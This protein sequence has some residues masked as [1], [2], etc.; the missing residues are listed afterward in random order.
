MPNIE[1]I[2]TNGEIQRRIIWVSVTPN[3]LYCDIISETNTDRHY[4]IHSDGSFWY[5]FAGMTIKDNQYEPLDKLKGRLQLVTFDFVPD[6]TRIYTPDYKMVKL[7]S[8]IVV[9]VRA[10]NEPSRNYITCT[11]DLIEPKNYQAL[12]GIEKFGGEI[13]VYTQFKQFAPWIVISIH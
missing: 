5:T 8:A 13:H 7:D 10:Y 11:L 4:S 3:G 9:D 2:A 12:E 1:V 6:I